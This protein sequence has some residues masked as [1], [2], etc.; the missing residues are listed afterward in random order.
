MGLTAAAIKAA[1]GREKHYKLTDS[2]GLH[3]LVL[4]SGQPYW[5]MNHRQLGR[6]KTLAF[7]VWP[8]VDL[9]DA[10][11]KRDEARRVLAKGIDPA[12]KLKPDKIAVRVA[13]ASTFQA[14]ADDRQPRD[15]RHGVAM[16]RRGIPGNR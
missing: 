9:A 6:S 15:R 12:E 8:E 7:G 1:K 3:L 16:Q 5:R 10:R 13:A 2:D 11:A 4:P 14:V